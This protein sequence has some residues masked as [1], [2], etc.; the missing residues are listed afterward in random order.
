MV[1]VGYGDIIPMNNREI[2][3]TI[4]L[5]ILTCGVFSYIVSE[6]LEIFKHIKYTENSIRDDMY[7]IK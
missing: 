5:M 7:L 3:F 2:I 4:F 6:I 1:T